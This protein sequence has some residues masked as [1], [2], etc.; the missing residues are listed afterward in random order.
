MSV[1]ITGTL[2]AH[3]YDSSLTL[4]RHI[5]RVAILEDD[6]SQAYVLRHCLTSAG[7]APDVFDRGQ[8]LL[9][10]LKHE[11]FDLL[12]LDWNVPDVTGIQILDH[13][14]NTL[15]SNMP[16]MLLT[17]RQDEQ[18]IVHALAQGA[19]DYI[20]K[21]LRPRELLARVAALTRNDKSYKEESLQFGDLQVD[22]TSRKISV[23]GKPLKLSLKDFD[24]ALYMLR[25]VGRVLGR[26]QI[27]DAVWEGR[28]DSASRTLD[29][30]MSRVRT[31][32][33]LVPP[34]WNLDAVYGRGYRLDRML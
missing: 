12:L 16:A 34:R 31:K 23:R 30:H 2:V 20:C 7:H 4:R 1:S 32:L 19:D 18:D 9:D 14:R 11:T 8:S 10:A 27:I 25:N 3:C 28:I 17:S 26:R 13:L 21:P 33:A 5:V 29:T 6:R 22:V 15:R 24:L